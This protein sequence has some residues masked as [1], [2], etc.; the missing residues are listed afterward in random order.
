MMGLCNE[1]GASAS[2]RGRVFSLI[3]KCSLLTPSY[4]GLP[5]QG[6]LIMQSFPDYPNQVAT[7]LIGLYCIMFISFLCNNYYYLQLSY[8]HVCT[9]LLLLTFPQRQGV[10][11]CLS[12]Y[13]QSL[14][15]WHIG[16]YTN[17]S[18]EGLHTSN[19]CTSLPRILNLVIMG[20]FD[21]NEIHES[22][23]S[24]YLRAR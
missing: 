8:L 12:S 18:Y 14:D 21:H 1:D 4:S 15:K 19:C 5:A 16:N 23:S 24:L 2:R 10:S 6:H 7:L 11:F 9:Y 3:E 17:I 20:T 13:S 22:L